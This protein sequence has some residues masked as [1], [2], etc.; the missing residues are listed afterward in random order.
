MTTLVWIGFAL[1]ITAIIC[2]GIWGAREEA[3]YEK[4]LEEADRRRIRDR[5]I[6]DYERQDY[7]E[8]H[9]TQTTHGKARYERHGKTQK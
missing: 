6:R 2:G 8:S 4:Q 3:R 5:Q 7:R 1:L 9:N